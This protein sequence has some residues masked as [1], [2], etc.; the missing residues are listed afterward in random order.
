MGFDSI[1]NSLS[2]ISLLLVQK[3][4]QPTIRASCLGRIDVILGTLLGTCADNECKLK[5]SIVVPDGVSKAFNS[6]STRNDI[7]NGQV[8]TAD[9]GSVEGQTLRAR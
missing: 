2:T 6:Y 8:R 5:T 7:D 9:N 4:S 1:G 3:I